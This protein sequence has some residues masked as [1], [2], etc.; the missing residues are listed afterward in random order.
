MHLYL[1]KYLARDSQTIYSSRIK[2]YFRRSVNS[3]KTACKTANN[4]INSPNEVREYS[5]KI[6]NNQKTVLNV[7]MLGNVSKH[8]KSARKN[9]PMWKCRN[10]AKIINNQRFGLC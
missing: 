6:S 3:Q 5:T 8:N 9:A 10:I 4:Q 7:E 1:A 2:K